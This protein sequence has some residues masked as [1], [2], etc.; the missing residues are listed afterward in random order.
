VK[1]YFTQALQL[2][3]II[4]LFTSCLKNE[5]EYLPLGDVKLQMTEDLSENSRTLHFNFFTEE[6]YECLDN[7]I[8]FSSASTTENIDIALVDVEVSVLC[9][10]GPGPALETIILGSFELGNYPVGIKVGE[11]ENTGTLHV[12]EDFYTLSLIN[13]Q[14]LSMTYD[15]LYRIPDNTFWGL[16]GYNE[17][18]A[19]EKIDE[20]FEALV[21]IGAEQYTLNTGDYGYFQADSA[22]KII[23]PED[24]GFEYGKSFFYDYNGPVSS[25]EEVVD[26]FAEMYSHYFYVY[27]YTSE[28]EY[29]ESNY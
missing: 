15:T 22:G 10:T 28:G 2:T 5:K 7:I 8:R 13:P 18:E 16:A 21:E 25:V 17:T 26:Q 1:K 12:A 20:F 29:F 4:A 24:I 14:M 11:V 19:E 6:E 27:V 9:L 3:F 23:V